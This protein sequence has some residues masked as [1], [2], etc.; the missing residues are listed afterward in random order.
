MMSVLHSRASSTS[1]TNEQ[2]YLPAASLTTETELGSAGRG[3]DQRTATSPILGSDSRRLL[4]TLK[5][6]LR[7]KRMVCRLSLRER[8]RGRWT[9]GPLRLPVLLAR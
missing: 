6:A 1:T 7:V 8:K 4:V 2:K 9:F 3:L 5:Q